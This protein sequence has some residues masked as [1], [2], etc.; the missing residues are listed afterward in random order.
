MSI[1]SHPQ[2]S[3]ESEIA[4]SWLQ[5]VRC[6]RLVFLIRSLDYIYV[7]EIRYAPKRF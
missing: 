4:V 1:C 7:N 6:W 5:A 2:A 3:P